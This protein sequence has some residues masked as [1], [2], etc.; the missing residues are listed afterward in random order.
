VTEWATLEWLLEIILSWLN[1]CQIFWRHIQEIVL[2]RTVH[3]TLSVTFK[4]VK[5]GQ[6]NFIHI[7]FTEHKYT[8]ICTH[9]FHQ[10]LSMKV[11]RGGWVRWRNSQHCLC[12]LFNQSIFSLTP[13]EEQMSKCQI[14]M[15]FQVRNKGSWGSVNNGRLLVF[16]MSLY[17]A[18]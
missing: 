5:S 14:K 12:S 7:L 3:S 16:W 1:M 9:T 17:L 11:H 10:A 6:T 4:M 8:S 15:L 2:Y 13:L 18:W